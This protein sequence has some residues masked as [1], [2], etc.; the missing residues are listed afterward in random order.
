M[1]EYPQK[2]NLEGPLNS[3][4]SIFKCSWPKNT[5]FRINPDS[6]FFDG[7]T[8]IDA[9]YFGNK[10][11]NKAVNIKVSLTALAFCSRLFSW[12]GGREEAINQFLNHEK[13]IYY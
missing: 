5:V 8:E 13:E 3:H 2:E 12:A 6:H 4:Q 1:G 10:M 9:F 11:R 7:I